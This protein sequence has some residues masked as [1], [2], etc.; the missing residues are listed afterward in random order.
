MIC[1]HQP[2]TFPL[3]TFPGWFQLLIQPL[4]SMTT[5]DN[6]LEVHHLHMK[7][8]LFKL[9]PIINDTRAADFSGL[10]NWKNPKVLVKYYEPAC[11]TLSSSLLMTVKNVSFFIG[12]IDD[13][14]TI[15]PIQPSYFTL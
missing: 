9:N 4:G 11:K 3:H 2:L 6:K 15:H 13:Y 10:I 7:E 14:F 1:V 12:K 8:L 5:S